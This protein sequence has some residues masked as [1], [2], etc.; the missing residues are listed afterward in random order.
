VPELVNSENG[1]FVKNTV[2]DWIQVLEM[3]FAKD[4]FHHYRISQ[5]YAKVFSSK[6]IG[7]QFLKSV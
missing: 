1:F 7:S 2:N 4:D 3:A 6:V 5:T